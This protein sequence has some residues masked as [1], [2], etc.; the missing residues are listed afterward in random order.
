MRPLRRYHGQGFCVTEHLIA[1]RAVGEVMGMSGQGRRVQLRL[2]HV[3]EFRDG[4]I[5]RENPWTDTATLAQ[6]LADSGDLGEGS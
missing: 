4:L 5:S 1:G 3:F 2:L 6:Q